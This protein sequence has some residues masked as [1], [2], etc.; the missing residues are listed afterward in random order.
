MPCTC[1]AG[2]SF[3][4]AHCPV[5]APARAGRLPSQGGQAASSRRT[6]CP[7]RGNGLLRPGETGCSGQGGQAA[8]ARRVEAQKQR[9]STWASQVPHGSGG[10]LPS[11]HSESHGPMVLTTAQQ[12]AALANKLE[13][14]QSFSSCRLQ[15]SLARVSGSLGPQ[16]KQQAFPGLP[17]MWL[18]LGELPKNPGT[19]PYALLAS[20]AASRPHVSRGGGVVSGFGA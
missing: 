8:P 17:C 7:A 20:V 14:S 2:V 3:M 15:S 1:Q 18:V 5:A 16:G 19:A 13:E 9:G 12:T 11:S 10:T 4:P 6:G